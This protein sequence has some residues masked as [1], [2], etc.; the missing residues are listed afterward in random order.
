MGE[1]CCF[2]HD[3]PVSVWSSKVHESIDIVLEVFFAP[4]GGHGYPSLPSFHIFVKYFT[5][6]ICVCLFCLTKCHPQA[7]KHDGYVTRSAN[8]SESLGVCT[9]GRYLTRRYL[10]RKNSRN[11]DRV[12]YRR[13]C[14]NHARL[15]RHKLPPLAFPTFSDWHIPECRPRLTTSQ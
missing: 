13:H 15:Q 14:Q 8:V 9:I 2:T 5:T 4:T 3:L 6:E 7:T 10:Y 11:N 12:T 1:K